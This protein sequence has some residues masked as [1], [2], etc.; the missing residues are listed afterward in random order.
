VE[1]C[2]SASQAQAGATSSSSSLKPS[3]STS[4]SSPSKASRTI[5]SSKKRKY[6][7]PKVDFLDA[8]LKK[9]RKVVNY[10]PDKNTV[11]ESD[12]K[13]VTD[14]LANNAGQSQRRAEDRLQLE[15]VLKK[16]TTNT[17]EDA[18]PHTS[19]ASIV[20]PEKNQQ[21]SDTTKTNVKPVR[22]KDDARKMFVLFQ[23][24]TNKCNKCPCFT[25]AG[26]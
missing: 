15:H 23:F 2:T 22:R 13:L 5:V 21:K 18:S 19:S 26:S 16:Y 10:V 11:S 1:T 8:P 4:N 17:D 20:D 24:L 9:R 25:F 3:T 7:Y 6:F 14:F 12:L